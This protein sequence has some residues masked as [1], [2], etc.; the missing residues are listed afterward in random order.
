MGHLHPKYHLNQGLRL[1][2]GLKSKGQG[3]RRCSM[4]KLG[5]L[6][7][8]STPPGSDLLPAHWL[9]SLHLSCWLLSS[10]HPG[11]LSFPGLSPLSLGRAQLFP[12]LLWPA[13]VHLCWD[14]GPCG[15]WPPGLVP[16][17]V[18]PGPETHCVQCRTISPS[19]LCLLLSLQP[20][21]TH[22]KNLGVDW[23]ALCSVPKSGHPFL[24]ILPPK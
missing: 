14:P 3:G 17:D 18:F 16:Q 9:L 10:A 5:A 2:N 22:A 6:F 11:G 19:R 4:I 24:L 7:L 8:D 12:R 15:H 20:P 1:Y 23:G 13:D 21:V